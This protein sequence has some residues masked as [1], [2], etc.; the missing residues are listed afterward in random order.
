MMLRAQFLLAAC[1]AAVCL[2]QQG[3]E[4]LVPS[5][6]QQT[7]ESS[8]DS[9]TSTKPVMSPVPQNSGETTAI[10]NEQIEAEVAAIMAI[11]KRLG[12]GVAETL[13]DFSVEMPKPSSRQAPTADTKPVNLDEEFAK[14][15]AEQ[16]RNHV[17]QNK[18]ESGLQ[19]AQRPPIRLQDNAPSINDEERRETI[20]HAAR[21]LEEAA[22]VL[23][24]ASV[25]DHADKIRGTAGELWRSAR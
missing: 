12:G 17:A 22:A 20:R 23:E 8:Q 2:P 15:L 25:Y 3:V 16:S 14:H 10:A 11:R 1:L 13:G 5:P 6:T 4:S 21:M 24:E 7:A 19:L 18:K 9:K